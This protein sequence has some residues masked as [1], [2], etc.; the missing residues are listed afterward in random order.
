[1]ETELESLRTVAEVS[2]AQLEEVEGRIRDMEETIER[3][4]QATAPPI[5]KVPECPV[6]MEEMVP[7]LRIHQCRH[8]HLVC[9]AC[10]P[11]LQNNCPTCRA[12]IM[13]RATAVEQIIRQALNLH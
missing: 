13:G 8:G 10:L 5:M 2:R 11:G 12:W 3:E 1:M 6:C 7:P 9:S 4:R